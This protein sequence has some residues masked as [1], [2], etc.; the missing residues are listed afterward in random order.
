MRIYAFEEWL[1]GS[2]A[3]GFPSL[4]I[5]P[6]T[7]KW[8]SPIGFFNPSI[9]TKIFS[10]SRN[11]DGLYQPFPIPIIQFCLSPFPKLREAFPVDNDFF[12]QHWS[13]KVYSHRKAWIYLFHQNDDI[14]HV[15]SFQSLARITYASHGNDF[16]LLNFDHGQTCMYRQVS[17]K[18]TNNNSSIATEINK[19]NRT[20][21]CCWSV[22]FFWSGNRF[23]YHIAIT[24]V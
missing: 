3:F 24:S 12:N 22:Y 1:L 20:Q 7:L 8:E 9:P 14:V 18:E 10:Q 11:P 23:K 4:M 6:S 5:L 2:S 16:L 17:F 13:V 15:R 19:I 21:F